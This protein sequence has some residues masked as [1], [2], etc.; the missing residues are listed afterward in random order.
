MRKCVIDYS[1]RSV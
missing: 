1:K